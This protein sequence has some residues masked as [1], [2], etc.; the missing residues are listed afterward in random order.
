MRES[1]MVDETENEDLKASMRT[2]MAMQL[3][4]N[5]DMEELGA[6]VEGARRERDVIMKILI[7]LPLFLPLGDFSPLHTAVFVASFPSSLPLNPHFPSSISLPRA[8]REDH[9]PGA[10]SFS[11]NLLK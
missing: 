3:R 6:E 11:S 9:H 1:V 7:S 2:I 10:C 8:T 4:T 5:S